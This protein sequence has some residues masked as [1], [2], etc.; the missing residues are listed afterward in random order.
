MVNFAIVQKTKTP[1]KYFGLLFTFSLFLPQGLFAQI[2]LTQVYLPEVG[3]TL[4]QATDNLPSSIE[5]SGPGPDQK[6]DYTT[7]QAPFSQSSPLRAAYEGRAADRFPEADGLFTSGETTQ[8]YYNITSRRMELVGIAGYDPLD[9]GLNLTVPIHPPILER[10]APLRYGDRNESSADISIAFPAREFP[11]DIMR[12]LPI[13][14]DSFRIRTA[15]KRES[16]VDA[17]GTLTIPGGI[18]DVLREKRTETTHVRL[19]GKL[20]FL[21]WQ[22]IT[23]LLP[24]TGNKPQN[25]TT[26]YHYFSNEAIEPIAILTTDDA[27]RQITQA[28]FKAGESAAGLDEINNDRP[29]V[30]AFPNPAIVNV[31]FEFTNLPPGEYTLTIFNILGLEVWTKNYYLNGDRT[32]K[33][34]IS[35]L[36]KGTYLYALSN[37]RGKTIATKRLIVFRP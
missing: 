4:F 11:A 3:D 25:T 19:E 1:M 32:E 5:I 31:R 29:G 17:W 15:F 10:R 12:Q 28:V 18:Y 20:G 7:L 22:D 13:R 6:W 8:Y 27:S 9:I 21:P 35:N 2:T 36:R 37:E 26:N 16:I 24:F 33:V 30:Y 23:G 34:D 14:P